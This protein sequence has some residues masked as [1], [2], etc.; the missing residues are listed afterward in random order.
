MI[1]STTSSARPRRRRSPS[2]SRP[3]RRIA[4][5]PRARSRVRHRSPARS[6]RRIVRSSSA[7]SS[8]LHHGIVTPTL[9][10]MVPCKTTLGLAQFLA[11][12]ADAPGNLGRALDHV[13]S[14]A[15]RGC[16]LIVLPELW[17]CGFSWDTLADDAA[18]GRAARRA[19][20]RGA[21]A[22]A[23]ARRLGARRHRA[24]AGGRRPLQHRRPRTG[25]TV[26]CAVHRKVRLYTPL[27]EDRAFSAGDALTVVRHPTSGRSASRRA[28]TATSPRWRARCGAPGR[29]S[30]CTRRPT[31]WPRSGGGR[32]VSGR[33][34]RQRAVVDR[35]QPVRRAR[36]P[37]RCSAPAG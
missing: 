13:A 18:R 33:R 10:T 23:K 30:C 32:A 26:G 12:P 4:R 19:P 8:E 20:R 35:R 6:V 22:A 29:G 17:P 27:G 16:D 7:P 31:R 9:P 5:R 2:P 28:S 37:G 11:T 14:L 1:A 3:R 24:G 36:R 25:P 21:V 34:P 15:S